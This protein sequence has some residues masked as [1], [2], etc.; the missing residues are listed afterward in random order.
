MEA[1]GVGQVKSRGG[2][3]VRQTRIAVL[4]VALVGSVPA[5]CRAQ[6]RSETASPLALQQTGVTASRRTP[7]VGFSVGL[8][9]SSPDLCLGCQTGLEI[10]AHVGVMLKWNLAVAA[11]GLFLSVAPNILSKSGGKQDGLLGT[12]QFWP[13]ER[14]WLKAGAGAG[15]V[16]RHTPDL[17]SRTVHPVGLGGIGLDFNPRSKFVVDLS[18]Q[19]LVSG[20]SP[21]MFADEPAHEGQ[22]TTATLMLGV[23]WRPK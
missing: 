8:G 21:S 2:G 13:T 3:R 19:A 23:T 20:D 18:V 6:T 9:N 5:I 1:E 11:Q 16:E 15:S 10:G 22:V 7:L 14:F 4:A 12:I 17:S